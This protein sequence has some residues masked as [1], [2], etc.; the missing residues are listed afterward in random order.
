MKN[1]IAQ[2]YEQAYKLA[3]NENI[4]IRVVVVTRYY[5]PHNP[6]AYTT[7]Q[8]QNFTNGLI[9]RADFIR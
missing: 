4:K 7:K 3:N 6:I 5:L 8:I 9:E 2:D 1:Q